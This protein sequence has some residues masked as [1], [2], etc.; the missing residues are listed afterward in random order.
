M[1]R[2]VRLATRGS[3]LAIAQ[4]N[5][6][7]DS[8]MA[9]GIKGEPVIVRSHG[10]IDVS[11][12]LYM[13]GERGIF[14]KKLNE[15]VLEG[16]VDGAV[17]SA[18]DI[19]TE[20][21][22][23]LEIS[24]YSKRGDPRDF[25]VSKYDLAQFAGTVG[26]SSIRR[27]RFLKLFNKKLQFR[28]IRGN[29]NTRIEKW[30][31]REVDSLVVAK[32]ALDRLGLSIPGSPISTDICPPDPNQ[33]FVAVVSQKG[34]TISKILS[35]M[36]DPRVRWEAETERE[37]MKKLGLGCDVAVS[38]FANYDLKKIYFSY[39]NEDSRF[40]L[41]FDETIETKDILKMRDIIGK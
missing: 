10:E 18:K 36:Q 3:E 35:S 38:V 33:G 7:S 37:I 28:D 34:S 12:P 32:V 41:S 21:D 27:R 4:F 40:D 1:E 24:Y 2:T 14:V 15:L 17:H 16:T 5:I 26:S 20:I 29:I 13:I 6:I 23:N 19:P 8:L 22:D 30:E 11:T 31:R 25:F 9:K 39:A